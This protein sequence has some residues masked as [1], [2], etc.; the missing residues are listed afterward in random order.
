MVNP[1]RNPVS[2]LVSYGTQFASGPES[3]IELDNSDTIFL[4]SE[5]TLYVEISRNA[6]FLDL[7][8]CTYVCE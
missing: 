6:S 2:V 1:C 5:L 8:V 4:T 3:R 7:G